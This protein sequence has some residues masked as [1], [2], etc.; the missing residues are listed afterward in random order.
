[1]QSS[2]LLLLPWL[3]L[4]AALSV[5]W[6]VWDHEHQIADKELRSQFDFALRESVSQI[7][8]RIVAYEQMLRGMQGLFAT[9]DLSNRNAVRDYVQTLQLDANFSGIQVL[10][11]I[12]RVLPGQK[13]EHIA[14]MRRL[15]FADYRIYPEGERDSYAPI[16]QR[17]PEINTNQ[18]ALG[19]DPWADPVRR[20]AMEKARDS[21]MPA[22]TGKV[23]LVIDKGA[24][25]R[26]GFVMYLPIFERGKP[27][28]SLLQRRSHLIGWVYASFR[29][30]DFMASLYGKQV[31]ELMLEIYDDANPMES[32][33]MYRSGAATGNRRP[34]AAP[35][36]ASEYMVVGG[37]T[38]TLMLR[39]QEAFQARFGRSVAS[40]IAVTGIGLS[41]LL[42]LLVWFMV[43]GRSRAL[44]LAAAMTEELRQ[45]AQHDPLTGLPNRALFSDR[46][47]HELA[48]AKRHEGHFAMIFLDLDNFKPVNDNYGHAVGD[49]VL[50][51]VARRLQDSV[52]A[53]DT[54]GRIGGD[55]FVVLMAELPKEEAALG[56]AEKIRQ[57]VRQPY[58]VDGLELSLSC[59]LGVAVY[60]Q[61]G[62]DEIALTKSADEAMYRVKDAG[63]DGVQMANRN[64]REQTPA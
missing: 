39:T 1:M 62:K 42:S 26:A 7:E 56:L 48:Y 10:G 12:R 4:F 46:V 61:D 41:I 31:P 59:S 14:A 60:P 29:M 53:S 43:T 44:Q 19:F 6:L 5:T 54:V 37:H 47:H 25:D 38:W 33:L 13:A 27:R 2:R 23:Q 22:L 30:N 15:G 40:V 57:T 58:R 3:V 64:A 16:I 17:E 21:G 51:E 34:S 8:Q 52:R 49:R 36:T 50:Q 20:L 24:E 55:E 63:R 35:L 18:I 11:V 45:M 28:D 32:A 9:T